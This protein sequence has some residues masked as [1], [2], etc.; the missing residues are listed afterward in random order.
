MIVAIKLLKETSVSVIKP[1]VRCSF[2]K[3][4]ASMYCQQFDNFI[5]KL[6]NE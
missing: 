5:R 2:S 6:V 1:D 4:Y 3:P